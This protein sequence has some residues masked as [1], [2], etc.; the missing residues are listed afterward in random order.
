MFLTTCPVN[1]YLQGVNRRASQPVTIGQTKEDS[2]GTTEAVFQQDE[3]EG[4][5]GRKKGIGEEEGFRQ[6]GKGEEQVTASAVTSFRRGSLGKPGEPF[7]Y[8]KVQP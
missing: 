6:E 5:E 7:L 2:N 8:S 3:E 1:G 4:A